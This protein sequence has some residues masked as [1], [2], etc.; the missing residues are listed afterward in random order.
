M[1]DV[2]EIPKIRCDNCGT[3]EEKTK[4]GNGMSVNWRKPKGWGSV[5]V[6]GTARGMYPNDIKMTDLCE[7]CHKIVFDA[8]GDAL[9]K[10][11]KE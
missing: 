1:A 7:A 9:K 10:A 4:D 3:V 2:T 8:V 11:R 6:S 5:H